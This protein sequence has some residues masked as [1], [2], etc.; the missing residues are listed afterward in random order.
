MGGGQGLVLFNG[1]HFR[2]ISVD[3]LMVTD[4]LIER[5]RLNQKHGCVICS[6]R[7]GRRLGKIRTSCG[8]FR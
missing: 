5:V 1:H 4:N 6:H 2:S 7:H 3:T 8:V